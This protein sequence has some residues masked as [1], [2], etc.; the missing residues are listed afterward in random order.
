VVDSKVEGQLFDDL[1]AGNDSDFAT[2]FAAIAWSERPQYAR[3]L[4]DEL[5]ANRSG[6]PELP[7]LLP[8]IE[9]DQYQ[10]EYVR[11]IDV[12]EERSKWNPKRWFGSERTE[13]YKIYSPNLT[14]RIAHRL[15]G[16]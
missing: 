11:S 8:H 3:A 12:I 9:L 1:K 15:L 10:K 4:E 5:R 7:E 13:Q 16:V 14:E 2:H 6:N